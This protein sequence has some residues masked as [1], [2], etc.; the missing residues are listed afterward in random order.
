[1]KLLFYYILHRATRGKKAEKTKPTNPY[2]N[3]YKWNG[4]NLKCFFVAVQLVF[5]GSTRHFSSL[6]L[7]LLFKKNNKITKTPPKIQCCMEILVLIWKLIGQRITAT[8]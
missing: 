8:R 5:S 3:E 4:T 6:L 1:M 2:R 7:F